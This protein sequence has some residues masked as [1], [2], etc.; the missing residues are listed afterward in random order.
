MAGANSGSISRRSVVSRKRSSELGRIP[1]ENSN[2]RCQACDGNRFLSRVDRIEET[3]DSINLLFFKRHRK[4]RLYTTT[5]R[6]SPKSAIAEFAGRF[7]LRVG[8]S[9]LAKFLWEWLWNS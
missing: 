3:T 7:S 5:E 1:K 8:A 9:L 2:A 4:T 6:R